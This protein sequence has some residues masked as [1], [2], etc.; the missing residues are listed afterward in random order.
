MAAGSLAPVSRSLTFVPG[1]VAAIGG[2]AYLGQP[3]H[4]A[5]LGAMAFA[6]LVIWPSLVV[7]VLLLG[8]AALAGLLVPP[9]IR[10]RYRRDL[11]R[12]GT[13]RDAQRSSYISKRLRRVVTAADRRRCS[14]CKQRYGVMHVDHCRPWIAG[15]R[16]VLSNLFLLCEHCNLVKSNYNKDRD[17]YEH[18]HGDRTNIAEARWILRRERIHR[19]NPLRWT[20]A[21]W[22][23]AS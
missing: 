13:P 20:R 14:A 17:G 5:G 21:A 6:G 9:S 2:W 3:L 10:G 16:T 11:I 18:Y 7:A 1:L 22:A 4:L 12:R 8:P 15:G 19:W 23:L